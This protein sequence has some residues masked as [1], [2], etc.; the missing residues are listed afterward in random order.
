MTSLGHDNTRVEAHDKTMG[1]RI[2]EENLKCQLRQH[3]PYSH[4]SFPSVKPPDQIIVKETLKPACR[5]LSCM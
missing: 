4:I 5:I 2:S 3:L 1:G